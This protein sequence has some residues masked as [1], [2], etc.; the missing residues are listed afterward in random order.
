MLNGVREV[1][2]AYFENRMEVISNVC[3]QNA[4]FMKITAMRACFKAF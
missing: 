1:I 4:Q 3:V 2:V